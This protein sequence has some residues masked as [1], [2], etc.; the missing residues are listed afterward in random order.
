MQLAKVNV[1]GSI[2]YP[3]SISEF[4]KEHAN[5]SFPRVIPP[6]MFE[7]YGIYIVV[8]TDP[9]EHDSWSQYVSGEPPIKT[10]EG[11]IQQW[12]VKDYS[13]EVLSQKARDERSYLLMQSDWLSLKAQEQG[14]DLD[15]SWVTYRQA[16]RDITDQEGFP[17]T[18]VWPTAPE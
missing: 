3:Y 6:E 16:L 1:D 18:I 12:S 9:P 15:A 17:R 8:E 5:V 2:V 4:R 7:E 10:N 11:V 14:V 13:D